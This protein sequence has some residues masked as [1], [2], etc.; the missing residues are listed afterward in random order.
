[1]QQSVHEAFFMAV[2]AILTA[3]DHLQTIGYT[4]FAQQEFPLFGI[5]WRGLLH[6][7][8]HAAII[9][10]VVYIVIAVL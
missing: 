6:R 1:M 10:L 3:V 8:D 7:I 5:T 9:V 2:A 4:G